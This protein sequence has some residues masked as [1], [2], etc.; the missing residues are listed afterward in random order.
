ML[1][2]RQIFGEKGE[3]IAVRYLKKKGYKILEKNYRT[4][5]GEIDIIAKDKD[6]I[7]FVEVK[8]RRSWQFGNPKGAVTPAKQRK[9][10]KVALYYLKTNDRSNAKARFDVVTITAT[11]DKSKIEIIKNAFELAY[12]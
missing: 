12:E 10:S 7:V 8:S 9:I 2:Q 4:K 6:T 11:R 1:N 3:S 5:L